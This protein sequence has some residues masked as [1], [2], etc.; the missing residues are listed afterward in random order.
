MDFVTLN[1]N[2]QHYSTT[3]RLKIMIFQV[4]FQIGVMLY[5]MFNLIKISP[6]DG[7]DLLLELELDTSIHAG[8][9]TSRD[10]CL[11][12]HGSDREVDT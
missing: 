7:P 3:E 8:A 5:V 1:H 6:H 10:T 2:G 12:Q 4:C 11:D 9:N